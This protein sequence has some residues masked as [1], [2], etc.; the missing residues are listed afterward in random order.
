[1]AGS[2][3]FNENK[4][5]PPG[6]HKRASYTSKKGHHVSPRCV[7]STSPYSESSKNFTRRMLARRESRLKAVGKPAT[8]RK[9]CPPGQVERQGYVRRFAPNIIQKGY[10]VKKSSGKA[11]RIHPVKSSV[12]VRPGCIK[13]RG[14]AGKLAP[15]EGFGFLHK[16]ELKKHG[17]GYEQTKEERHSALR[18]AV[19]EFGPISVFRKVDVV[20]KLSKRT[21]P[22]ASKVFKADREW[23]RREYELKAP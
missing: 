1:M 23:I 22:E 16:G 18:R 8:S 19:K 17:Y 4:G 3:P 14:L 11:Y 13:D 21:V 9:G 5:C 10:T 12:Y 6:F 20:A 2:L 15:G 7:K